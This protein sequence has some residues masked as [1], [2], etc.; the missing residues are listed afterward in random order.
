MDAIAAGQRFESAALVGIRNSNPAALLQISRQLSCR[1]FI[2]QPESALGAGYPS[3]RHLYGPSTKQ[4]HL[5][6][7]SLIGAAD[8][9]P[10]LMRAVD[11]WQGETEPLR[12]RLR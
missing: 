4:R 6:G 2:Q 3:R 10:D 12:W 9:E 1:V 7:R 8:H 11:H 5:Y